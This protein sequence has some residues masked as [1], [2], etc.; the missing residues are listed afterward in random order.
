MVNILMNVILVM[1]V[2]GVNKCVRNRIR[3]Q[4]VFLSGSRSGPLPEFNGVVRMT[5]HDGDRQLHNDYRASYDLTSS[6]TFVSKPTAITEGVQKT[7]LFNHDKQKYTCDKSQ[8]C[9]YQTK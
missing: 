6:F 4:R 8:T 1:I 7:F 3:L 2:L 5:L 9:R